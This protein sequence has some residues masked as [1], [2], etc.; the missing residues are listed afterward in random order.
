VDVD[1][2]DAAVEDVACD[3]ALAEVVFVGG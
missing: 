1:T 3:V 2:R